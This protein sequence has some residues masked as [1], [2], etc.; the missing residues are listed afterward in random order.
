MGWLK[1]LFGGKRSLDDGLLSGELSTESGPGKARA[2]QLVSARH[3]AQ[4]AKALRELVQEAD[5]HH[6][7]VFSADLKVNRLAIRNAKVEILTLAKDLEDLPQVDPRGVILA[8][9][10]LRDGESPV[11]IR[12]AWEDDEGEVAASVERARVALQ[13]ES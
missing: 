10:L 1:G 4:A 11:Y 3:R 9:R 2:E 5:E 6:A 7:S 12:G 8:D 13:G